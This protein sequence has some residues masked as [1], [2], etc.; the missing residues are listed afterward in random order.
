MNV[1]INSFVRGRQLLKK[2]LIADAACAVFATLTRESPLLMGLFG[3]AVLLIFGAIIY[4]AVKYCR[5]PNCGKVI[6]LGVLAVESCPR[7]RRNLVTG[8]K[9]KKSR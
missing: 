9:M 3:G 8:R 6:I 5:C 7:C 4:I 2:L 1:Y